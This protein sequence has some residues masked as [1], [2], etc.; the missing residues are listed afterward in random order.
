MGCAE[1]VV[2]L[3]LILIK[4]RGYPFTK[5]CCDYGILYLLFDL[6]AKIFSYLDF[7]HSNFLI[8]WLPCPLLMSF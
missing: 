3:I 8:N 4:G 7:F 1:G 5:L 6:L 2:I